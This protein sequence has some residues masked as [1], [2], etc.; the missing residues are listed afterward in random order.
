[1]AAA[2]KEDLGGS[3][4]STHWEPSDSPELQWR[5]G[6]TPST[7]RRRNRI[8][9][10]GRSITTSETHKLRRRRGSRDRTP[11]EELRQPVSSPEPTRPFS[12]E[13]L[14]RLAPSLDPT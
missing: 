2:K 3:P 14:K 1:M 12:S 11:R 5:V 8:R 4:K 9:H 10:D 7:E 6:S 13:E